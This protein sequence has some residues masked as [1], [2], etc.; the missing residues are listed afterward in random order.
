MCVC[1]LCATRTLDCFQGNYLPSSLVSIAHFVFTLYFLLFPTLCPSLSVSPEWGKREETMTTI[2]GFLTCVGGGCKLMLSF[3]LEFLAPS[4]LWNTVSEH[5]SIKTN[6]GCFFLIEKAVD[7]DQCEHKHTH[8]VTL[9]CHWLVA[10]MR[11]AL[12]ADLR[13]LKKASVTMVIPSEERE[14]T[15][16]FFTL[17]RQKRLHR[18]SVYAHVWA[19]VCTRVCYLP[20]SAVRPT[21]CKCFQT[22]PWQ[23]NPN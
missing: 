6:Y 21:Q 3:S 17:R 13:P 22:L 11:S 15:V 18:V 23:P 16:D 8:T 19:C 1:P 2:W 7:G 14:S 20:D 12:L 4:E 9:Q 10:L 5:M